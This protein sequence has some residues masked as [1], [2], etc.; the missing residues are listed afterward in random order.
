LFPSA[1]AVTAVPTRWVSKTG[2]AAMSNRS[3]CAVLAITGIVLF[4]AAALLGP[5][6]TQPVVRN[7]ISTPLLKTDTSTKPAAQEFPGRVP[8][9]VVNAVPTRLQLLRPGMSPIEVWRTLGLAEY[10]GQLI[11]HG[12][13]P[14][15]D[16]R[17]CYYLRPID[18][19]NVVLVFDES[20]SNGMF[21]PAGGVFK[22]AYL[23]GPGWDA[24]QLEHGRT[25]K[26][27]ES[28][29][30]RANTLERFAKIQPGVSLRIVAKTMGER[31]LDKA[32]VQ[33]IGFQTGKW[34]VWVDGDTT[35]FRIYPY[36]DESEAE[37]T[38]G[39]SCIVMKVDQEESL[40][41]D[42]NRWLTSSNSSLKEVPRLLDFA[43][44]FPY[45]DSIHKSLA[46]RGAD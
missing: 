36:F 15:E 31:W 20:D 28:E 8:L 42:L 16:Y 5:S 4:L 13:G 11:V 35:V 14:S 3:Q 6:A 12:G 1:R 37:K 44:H 19:F 18:G 10:E 41:G 9:H 45:R 29:Q 34:Y 33:R 46:E 26:R 7:R 38:G 24:A 17:S 32:V 40:V 30:L 22:R 39:Y 21:D 27:A 2:D 23:A 43:V 25:A